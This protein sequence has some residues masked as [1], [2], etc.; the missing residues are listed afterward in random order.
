MKILI[1]GLFLFFLA[2]VI[3]FVIWRLNSKMRQ[4]KILLKIFLAIFILSMTIF[5]LAIFF[6]LLSDKYLPVKLSEHIH[7]GLFFGVLA[8]AYIATYPALDVDS[9]SLV[10]INLVANAGPSGF[11]KDKLKELAADDILVKPRIND[12]LKCKL[13][14]L[15][16]GRYKLAPKGIWLVNIFIFYRKILG[17]PKGG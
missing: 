10:I 15:E 4:L 17:L 5:Y 2:I 16:N 13:I 6:N 14:Y 3:H 1:W 12:L 7:I 9:P 8:A 11:A